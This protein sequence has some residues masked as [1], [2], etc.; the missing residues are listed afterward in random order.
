MTRTTYTGTTSTGQIT[1]HQTERILTAKY[2][3]LHATIDAMG[4]ALLELMRHAEATNEQLDEARLKY[5]TSYA[6]WIAARMEL[7]KR[8]PGPALTQLEL[9]WNTKE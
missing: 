8:Y 1:K 9:P 2:H 5:F 7:R 4:K 6:M 3:S